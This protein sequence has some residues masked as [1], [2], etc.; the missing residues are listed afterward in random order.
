VRRLSKC[1]PYKTKQV[2][3]IKRHAHNQESNQ[4]TIE[5]P[6]RKPQQCDVSRRIDDLPGF[7]L[8]RQRT[9]TGTRKSMKPKKQK[10]RRRS[11]KPKKQNKEKRANKRGKQDQANKPTSKQ[12]C[13]LT[14]QRNREMHWVHVHVQE[15]TQGD[16]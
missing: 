13:K 7:R 8:E 15:K 5:F 16:K 14:E 1:R 3:R 12:T 10:R 9:G 6:C 11:K 2:A 4:T